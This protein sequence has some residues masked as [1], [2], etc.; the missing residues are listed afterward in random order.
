MSARGFIL[1][2]ALTMALGGT[3]SAQ[4]V[5]HAISGQVKS[6]NTSSKTVDVVTRDGTNELN[7]DENG[8]IPLDFDKNLREGTVDAEKFQ[9]VGDYALVYYYG[10]D[11]TRTVV[12]FK[13]LGAGPFL[14]MQGTVVGFDKENRAM[15][16]KD[17]SGKTQTFTLA[18]NLVL[19]NDMGVDSGRK[20]EPHKGTQMLVTYSQTGNRNTAV[21]VRELSS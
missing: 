18:G 8:K 11:T 4:M 1:T 3:A 16:L 10:F 17:A 13:D 9:H 19:D 2:A 5:V 7:L 14:K 12:A 20:Y 6:I 21:F 15:T